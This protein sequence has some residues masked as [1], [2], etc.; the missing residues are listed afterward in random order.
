[1]E[2]IDCNRNVKCDLGAC[3]NRATHSI[4]PDRV[5]VR[6]YV[7]VCDKC[8]AELHSAIGAAIVP[9]SVETAKKKIKK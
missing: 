9:K 1:M 8:L 7:N 2:I 4:K 3:R 6:G 5:G